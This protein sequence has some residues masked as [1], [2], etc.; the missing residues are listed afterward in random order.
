MT[1]QCSVEPWRFSPRNPKWSRNRLQWWT[2]RVWQASKLNIW[3]HCLSSV[4]AD[5]WCRRFGISCRCE[6]VPQANSTNIDPKLWNG[7][8]WSDFCRTKLQHDSAISHSNVH[9]YTPIGMKAIESSLILAHRHANG[10]CELIAYEC[11]RA[12][13]RFILLK[14]STFNSI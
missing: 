13:S 1:V 10:V 7:L 3:C 14:S 4:N 12:Q 5:S 8:L 11:V 9:L 6:E 2:H